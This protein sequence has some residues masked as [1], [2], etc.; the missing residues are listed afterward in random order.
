MLV[1]HDRCDSMADENEAD[2]LKLKHSSCVELF[3]TC[4][5]SSSSL[6]KGKQKSFEKLMKLHHITCEGNR[7]NRMNTFYQIRFQPC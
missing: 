2:V 4:Q 5:L 1:M 7:M 6:G 3:A